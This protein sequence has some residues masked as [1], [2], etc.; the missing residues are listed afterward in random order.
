MNGET[1]AQ[2][3]KFIF[4]LS[5]NNYAKANENLKSVINEKINARYQ[6]QLAQLK[7]KDKK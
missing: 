5:N 7:K 4:N 2:I 3:Q 1:Q 6:E